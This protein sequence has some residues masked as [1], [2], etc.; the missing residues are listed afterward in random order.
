MLETLIVVLVVLAAL[1]AAGALGVYRR[2]TGL[3]HRL[4]EHIRTAAPEMRVD[5]TEAGLAVQVL[6]TRIEVD[7]PVLARR[8]PRGV[9]ER[10]WFDAIV[11][12]LRSR[13]PIPD[14]PPYPLVADRIVPHLKPADY[15]EVFDRYPPGLRLAWREFAPGVAV[16]YVI[17]GL[18]RWTLVTAAMARA[19][20]LS[21]QALH[22]VALANLRA[23]T[24]R[25]LAEVGGPQRRYEHLDGFDAARILAADLVVPPD[26]ADPLVAIP[27]E[28]VL[29]IGPASERS[30]LADQAR[31]RFQTSSRPLTPH[32]YRLTPA[33]AVEADS[34]GAGPGVR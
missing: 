3:C 4:A 26:V 12:G 29:W 25:M 20:G 1:A 33:G 16:I 5:L 21:P 11:A 31:A 22:E 15:V 14:P 17:A 30:A 34:A 23:Q 19:W 6:G 9:D 7:L 8:R 2:L 28:T 24:V 27:E 32:L 13:V 18:H 10:A